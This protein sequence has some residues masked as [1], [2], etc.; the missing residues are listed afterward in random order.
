M[1]STAVAGEPQQIHLVPAV[2]DRR[3][4]TS[5]SEILC[6][7]LTFVVN[8]LRESLILPDSNKA[9]PASDFWFGRFVRRNVPLSSISERGF[10]DWSKLTRY[11]PAEAKNEVLA[12]ALPTRPS[13]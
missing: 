12:S 9:I 6:L 13:D 10:E 2:L 11:G 8:L 5:P 3:L 7:V 1:T 4:P